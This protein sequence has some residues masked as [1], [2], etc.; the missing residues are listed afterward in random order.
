MY[1]MYILIV[2]CLFGLYYFQDSSQTKSVDWTEFE[3]AAKAGEISKIEV[4]PESGIAI[5]VL[6]KEGA[7]KQKMHDDMQGPD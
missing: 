7:K 5:G 3:A 4:V 6:T 2:A 1:W